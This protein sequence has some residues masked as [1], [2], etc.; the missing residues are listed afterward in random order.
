MATT[1]Q[2][3][4]ERHEARLDTY[5][6]LDRAIDDTIDEVRL[7]GRRVAERLGPRRVW[8][9]N[10]TRS[11]GGVSEMMPAMCALLSDAGVD[12]RWLVL[13]TDQPGFFPITKALHNAIH[14]VEG[15]DNLQQ[16]RAV[17]DRVC[18]EAAEHLRFVESGDVLVVHDPQP[19][20]VAL[21]LPERSRPHVIW[22]CHIGVPEENEHTRRAWGFLRPYLEP[23]QRFVFSAS[24]YVPHEL[25][26]KSSL[27]APGIDPLDHKNRALQPYKL[28]GV[29][30]SSGLLEGPPVRA[31]A[32]FTAPV[33]R[34]GDGVWSSEPIDYLLH[35]PMVLQVSRFDRLKG[36]DQL[37]PS[38]ALLLAHGAAM[39]EHRRV[40]MD[41]LRC[42]L[43][44]AQLVMAGPDPSGVT[45]DPEAQ[46]VLAELCRQHEQLPEDLRRRVH[47]LRLPM[48]SR[49][50]NALTVNA[51]QRAAFVIVQNSLREGFGL[52]A[53]EAMWKAVPLVAANRGGLAV[54]V[55]HGIDGVLVNDPTDH[56]ELA[57]AM[58]VPFA[59]PQ[60]AA[61]MALSARH[62]AREHFLVI[63]QVRRW[64]EEFEAALT[65]THHD[66]EAVLLS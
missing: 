10:S 28:I 3:V 6:G 53:T 22:R 54:Q 26:H 1:I 58:L 59:Y 24:S 36:F 52:T 19:A 12:T 30:T 47:L 39:A 62:R 4:H 14:G 46:E 45:D 64:L 7:L 66:A 43:E 13:Q 31:W 23:Y 63:T 32:Q 61:A 48:Q 37:I 27:I 17:Y 40:N 9:L 15:H 49:K 8:M 29:L 25:S 42:E 16:G 34:W 57:R 21:H 56:E 2:E 5:L 33:Q 65:A 11:G 50:Q 38:F 41:R 51:L 60:K 20:G 18:R 55:R 35:R 44:H